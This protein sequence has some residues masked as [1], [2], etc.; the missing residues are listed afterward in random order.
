VDSG[1]I[2][3]TKTATSVNSGTFTFSTLLIPGQT[4]QACEVIMP[5]WSTTL[6]S[7]VPNSFMPP[8][9]VA[10]NPSVVTASSALISPWMPDRRRRLPWT[11]LHLPEAARSRLASGRTGH[12]VPTVTANRSRFS[13]RR[14]LFGAGGLVVSAPSGTF[15]VFGPTYYLRLT[16]TS[17]T[18]AVNLLNKSTLTGAKKASDPA[19]NL[20]AQLVGAELNFAA[21][22]GMTPAAITAVNQA[23]LLLGKYQVDGNGYVG[24]ISAADA[25]T[26]NSLAT[27]LDHYNNDI[28]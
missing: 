8:D 21:G 7:F 18:A 28:P 17:C 2:L 9:G 12:P 19:F 27:T 4:Y 5:G 10:L 11:K 22:A 13:I 15:G 14:W 26:M 23:V 25:T 1:T 20:A 16:G 3:E 6:G 24:K